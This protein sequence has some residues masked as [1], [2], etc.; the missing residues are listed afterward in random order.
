MLHST[1]TEFNKRY[2]GINGKLS[3][4]KSKKIVDL[5][6]II[7]VLDDYFNLC[8]EEY[9]FC[10]EGRIHSEAWGSW[11]R[12]MQEHLSDETIKVYWKKAQGEGSYYGLTTAVINRGA[13]TI[14]KA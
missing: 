8:S 11:C 7:K 10:K 6:M 2:N 4:I 14:I 5:D 1:V 12:G 13:S 3:D 9:L